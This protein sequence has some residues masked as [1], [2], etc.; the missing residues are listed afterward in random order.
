DC[1]ETFTAFSL[2]VVPSVLAQELLNFDAIVQSARADPAVR[3]LAARCPSKVQ[4]FLA[5]EVLRRLDEHRKKWQYL[6]Y[7]GYGRRELTTLR[8]Y[9]D[10]L[11]QQLDAPPSH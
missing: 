9:V 10:R 2:P 1:E 7:H 5:P 8:Q 4:L 3:E 6:A 11:V